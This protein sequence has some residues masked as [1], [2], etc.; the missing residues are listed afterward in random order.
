MPKDLR[1]INQPSIRR[2]KEGRKQ[3]MRLSRMILAPAGS[4]PSTS[5]PG[6]T[7]ILRKRRA[8]R[9]YKRG[10]GHRSAVERLSSA[11]FGP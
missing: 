4:R 10:S 5:V 6:R 9:P 8:G 11:N 7:S 2:A 3:R 1:E